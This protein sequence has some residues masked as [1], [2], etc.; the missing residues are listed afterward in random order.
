MQ[1]PQISIPATKIFSSCAPAFGN[2]RKCKKCKLVY[3]AL[4]RTARRDVTY[5]S[6]HCLLRELGTIQASLVRAVGSCC[7]SILLPNEG[8][9]LHSSLRTVQCVYYRRTYARRHSI[10]ARDGVC[11]RAHDSARAK[12]MTSCVLRSNHDL[13]MAAVQTVAR[14]EDVGP[15][16]LAM[17]SSDSGSGG[18][19]DVTNMSS[20]SNALSFHGSGKST[21]S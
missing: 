11:A 19:I 21:D 4:T 9:W 2:A 6:K 17:D 3:N 16:S 8:V 13:L 7:M 12:P 20:S 14:E 5:L 18:I 15:L 1:H 10:L